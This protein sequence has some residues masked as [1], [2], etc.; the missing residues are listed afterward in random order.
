[1]ITEDQL[2]QLALALFQDV[3]WSTAHSLDIALRELIL[4]PVSSTTLDI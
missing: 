3:G 2:E 1:M 4:L